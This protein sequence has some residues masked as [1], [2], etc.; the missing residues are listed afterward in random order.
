MQQA[1]R[2]LDFK[3]LKQALKTIFLIF[4]ISFGGIYLEAWHTNMGEKTLR[5]QRWEG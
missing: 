5:Q 2:W 4:T 1:M 3:L